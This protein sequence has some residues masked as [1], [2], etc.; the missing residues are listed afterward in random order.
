MVCLLASY[1]FRFVCWLVIHLGLRY[2]LNVNRFPTTQF[3]ELPAEV[4]QNLD[5][6]L[7]VRS[8]EAIQLL[9][10]SEDG[11]PHA[12]QLSVGEFLAIGP[13]VLLVT[14]AQNAYRGEPAS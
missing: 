1:I 11:W 7:K 6:N 8:G 9:T 10:V 4:V 5:G 14:L 13:D 3:Q 2:T 12:A